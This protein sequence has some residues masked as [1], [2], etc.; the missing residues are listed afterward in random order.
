MNPTL[1]FV[2]CD[3]TTTTGIYSISNSTVGN[4]LEGTHSNSGCRNVVLVSGHVIPHLSRLSTTCHLGLMQSG[5]YNMGH[6]K[7]PHYSTFLIISVRV[8]NVM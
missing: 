1:R 8:G 2:L 4:D 6:N 7:Q 3:L 5:R